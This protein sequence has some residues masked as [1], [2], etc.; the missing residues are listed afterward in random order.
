MGEDKQEQKPHMN[1]NYKILDMARSVAG[2]GEEMY[3]K[4]RSGV[5]VGGD[6]R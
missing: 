2:G 6:G 1:P 5:K 3:N 4:E